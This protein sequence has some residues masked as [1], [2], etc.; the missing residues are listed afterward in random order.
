[1]RDTAIELD[2]FNVTYFT[3]SVDDP[4]ANKKFAESLGV[5]YAI[6][7]DPEKKTAAAYGVLNP[8]G[9]YAQR[10]TF[11]ID[12]QGII[13]DI[14]TKVNTR[15]HGPDLAKKLAVLGAPKR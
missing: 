1:V 11:I 14:D 8:S 9:Q 6:L 13:R 7:S 15:T 12:D 10:W 2:K 5:K 3:A 4:E